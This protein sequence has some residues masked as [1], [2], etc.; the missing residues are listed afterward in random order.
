MPGNW[1]II[2]ERERCV[3]G[4]VTPEQDVEQVCILRSLFVLRTAF[5]EG[6]T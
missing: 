3:A 1:V 6:R 2:Y 5:S 4:T